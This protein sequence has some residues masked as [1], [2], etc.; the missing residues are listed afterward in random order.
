MFNRATFTPQSISVLK[1]SFVDVAGPIVATI[2]VFASKAERRRGEEGSV[3][4]QCA[5]PPGRAS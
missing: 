2:F 3:H 1:F 4:S 5:C